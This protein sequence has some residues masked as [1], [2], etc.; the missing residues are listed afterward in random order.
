LRPLDL[1]S[2]FAPQ[3][4]ARS[5]CSSG[6]GWDTG[7]G[8]EELGG[9]GGGGCS[10][11]NLDVTFVGAGLL[12]GCWYGIKRLGGSLRR[13]ALRV[14]RSEV[15]ERLVARLTS[16]LGSRWR[17][18]SF[19]VDSL[20]P[21][22]RLTHLE[23]DAPL[24]PALAASLLGGALL[25]LPPQL[26]SPQPPPPPAAPAAAAPQSPSRANALPKLQSLSLY[27]TS[28]AAPARARAGLHSTLPPPQ[29]PLQ[30]PLLPLRTL[31]LDGDLTGLLP[32]L[33]AG[34]LTAAAA[35]RAAPMGRHDP[36]GGGGPGHQLAEL[37]LA[38][39]PAGHPATRRLPLL[40][41]HLPG[42]G[43]EVLHLEG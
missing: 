37:R 26:A 6:S 14:G 4:S 43:L 42:G 16:R 22:T 1:F 33:A 9:G 39:R 11:T 8:G 18:D 13:L 3:S 38:H 34:V 27:G 23:L 41:S 20:G 40:W 30:T 12:P 15:E 35:A 24:A 7:G 19:A 28:A 17:P 25:P 10:L 31:C 36:A 2:A 5:S 29:H 32:D 21:L